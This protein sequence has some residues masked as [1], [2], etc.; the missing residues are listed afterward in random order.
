[1][2]KNC[3]SKKEIDKYDSH[4]ETLVDLIDKIILDDDCSLKAKLTFLSSLSV[5]MN[6]IA[7][8]YMNESADE[9]SIDT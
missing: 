4:S 5:A 2:D 9:E 8:Y 3:L 6:D 7:L 1:M